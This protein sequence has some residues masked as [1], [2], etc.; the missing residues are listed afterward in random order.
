M[1]HSEWKGTSGVR[2]GSNHLCSTSNCQQTP[3]HDQM[4]PEGRIHITSRISGRLFPLYPKFQGRRWRRGVQWCHSLHAEESPSGDHQVPFKSPC[5]E[6]R[7]EVREGPGLGGGQ[8]ANFMALLESVWGCI[9]WASELALAASTICIL[10][11][12]PH[13]YYHPYYLM[14]YFFY[15]LVLYFIKF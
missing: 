11:F 2:W 1:A 8:N 9:L 10:L 13:I 6:V 14:C 7:A 5:T 3:W 15:T 4:N 12:F